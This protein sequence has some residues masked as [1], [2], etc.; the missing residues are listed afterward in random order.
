MVFAIL[1][2]TTWPTFSFLVTCAT[3]ASAILFLRSRQFPLAQD[4]EHPGAVLLHGADLL[5]AV[6][7]PHGHLELETKHL[8]VHV[9]Q[10]I[11]DLVFVEIANFLGFHK[12]SLFSPPRRRGTENAMRS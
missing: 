4:G 5:Q 9:L 12:Q 8:L 2:E 6:H 1:V 3:C 7:L 11:A 10:L